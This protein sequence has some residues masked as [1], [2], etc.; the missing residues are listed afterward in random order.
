[1]IQLANHV[2]TVDGKFFRII[3]GTVTM[4]C[5]V[6]K[7]IADVDWSAKAL[8]RLLIQITQHLSRLL[9]I[10]NVFTALRKLISLLPKNKSNFLP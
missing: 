8:H 4:C 10:L 2:G 3:F 7:R 6:V 5:D 1:M 9:S